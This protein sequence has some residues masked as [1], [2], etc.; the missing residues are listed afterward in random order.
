MAVEGPTAGVMAALTAALASSAGT[1][2]WEEN[3]R[4]PLRFLECGFEAADPWDAR[5]AI[6]SALADWIVGVQQPGL[7]TRLIGQR[8]TGFG[9]EQHSRIVDLAQARLAGCEDGTA[10]QRARVRHRLA[11]YLEHHQSVVL[12]GF[13]TFRLKDYMDDLAAAVDQAVEAFVLEREYREFLELLRH[14]VESRPDRP[15]RIHCLLRPDGVFSLEDDAGA[16]LG[17]DM[18]IADAQHVGTE[19]LLVSSLVTLAPQRVELHLPG[20]GALSGDALTTLGEVFVGAVVVC[21][22][23]ERCACRARGG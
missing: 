16:G 2:V 8:Y 18:D 19:D 1:L 13:I 10:G 6:A 9:P 15:A 7:L 11:E 12:D 14:L 4:G 17:P 23:C 22:G 21:P 3:R 5:A 20:G